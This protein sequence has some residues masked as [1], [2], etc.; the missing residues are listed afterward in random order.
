MD[1]TK[2][3]SDLMDFFSKFND[4]VYFVN[5]ES[6]YR[7]TEDFYESCKDETLIERLDDFWLK[8]PKL[9]ENR[10][11]YLELVLDNFDDTKDFDNWWYAL[12]YYTWQGLIHYF[13]D[14][15]MM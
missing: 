6:K 10:Q 12:M 2:E 13:E 15:Y 4:I 1:R 11:K 5:D 8:L 3:N 14:N 7:S 9:E